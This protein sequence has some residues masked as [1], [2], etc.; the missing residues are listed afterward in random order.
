[1][2]Q[3]DATILRYAG[4]TLCDV[5]HPSAEKVQGTVAVVGPRGD[6]SAGSLPSGTCGRRHVAAENFPL[7]GTKK[8]GVV[9]QTAERH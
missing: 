9:V 5:C 6:Q 2:I 3:N 4:S 8:T 1:M 7:L